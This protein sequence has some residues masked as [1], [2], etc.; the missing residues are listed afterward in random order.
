MNISHHHGS[1]RQCGPRPAPRAFVALPLWFYAGV[2]SQGPSA[3]S[4]APAAAPTLHPLARDS[5]SPALHPFCEAWGPKGPP[6]P[7]PTGAF[8]MGPPASFQRQCRSVI[9][10]PTSV[11]YWVTLSKSLHLSN[12][13]SWSTKS[14]SLYL[15]LCGRAAVGR[16]R[17]RLE[18]A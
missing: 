7:I 5:P 2:G 17:D 15:P 9:M 11:T 4:A 12:P 6:C 1:V 3:W 18:G 13:V 10:K 8:K 16:Q 14:S